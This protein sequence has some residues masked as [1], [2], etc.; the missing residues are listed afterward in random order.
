MPHKDT[1]LAIQQA[2]YTTSYIYNKLYIQQG[3]YTTS[4][5][6]RSQINGGDMVLSTQG[7]GLLSHNNQHRVILSSEVYFLVQI[8]IGLLT[9]LQVMRCYI[10]I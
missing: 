8:R 5:I 7:S 9:A 3:I 10:Y 1:S 6:Y 2:I 4:Y